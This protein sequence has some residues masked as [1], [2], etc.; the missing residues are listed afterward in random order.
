MM[1]DAEGFRGG[2]AGRGR[3]MYRMGRRR[4]NKERMVCIAGA[5]YAKRLSI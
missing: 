5:S 2:G 3:R 1:V 4:R